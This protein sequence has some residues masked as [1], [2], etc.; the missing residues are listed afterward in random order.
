MSS[1]GE[2][3]LARRIRD[4]GKLHVDM[5]ARLGEQLLYAVDYLDCAG[6]NHRDIKPANI[7]VNEDAAARCA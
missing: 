2:R 6:I 5:L 1:A 7:G 4:D 3:T